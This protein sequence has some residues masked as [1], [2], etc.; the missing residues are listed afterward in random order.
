MS[1][2]TSSLDRGIIEEILK[3]VNRRRRKK[4]WGQV[5]AVQIKLNFDKKEKR[6]CINKGF[7]DKIRHLQN[8]VVKSFF[9]PFSYFV[10]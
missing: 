5:T 1:K 3:K 2:C 10:A 8:Q 7:S 9:L 4:L 6:G